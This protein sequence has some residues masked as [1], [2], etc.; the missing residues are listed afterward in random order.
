MDDATSRYQTHIVKSLKQMRLVLLELQVTCL[1]LT[2]SLGDEQSFFYKLIF[3]TG[4][5]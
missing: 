1:L 2:C 4:R 3:L 5:I